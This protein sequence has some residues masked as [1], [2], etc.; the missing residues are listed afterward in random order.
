M[1]T[2][3]PLL[4]ASL[5][6]LGACAPGASHD[7]ADPVGE[8]DVDPV[9]LRELGLACPVDDPCGGDGDGDDD[10]DT[11]PGPTMSLA[12]SSG[13]RRVTV[14]WAN[15]PG[16]VAVTVSR[17]LSIDWTCTADAIPGPKTVLTTI[18]ANSGIKTFSD[19]GM[20]DDAR[21]FYFVKYTKNGVTKELSLSVDSKMVL[22]RGGHKLEVASTGTGWA[23]L[24]WKDEFMT[25]DSIA[26][27]RHDPQGWKE[28]VKKSSE[29]NVTCKKYYFTDSDAPSGAFVCYR[30]RIHTQLG[31]TSY[32][33]ERCDW[34]K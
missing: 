10:G 1:V 6:L 16:D 22:P 26:L 19:Y 34:T 27:E 9:G 17:M 13:Q 23:S 15:V 29:H 30:L 20:A 24:S 28:L 31:Y 33:P 14:S 5:L 7:A 12:Y 8:G 18:A 11:T 32:G 3:K 4:F 25:D 21:W 2:V